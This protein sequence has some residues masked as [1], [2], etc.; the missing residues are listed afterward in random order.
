MFPGAAAHT[1]ARAV[2]IGAPISVISDLEAATVK[3]TRAGALGTNELWASGIN[4]GLRLL[5][6]AAWRGATNAVGDFLSPVFAVTGVFTAS[7]NMT[8]WAQCATGVLE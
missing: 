6:P 4:R 8:I 5:T 7:Y 2:E 1:V 3:A